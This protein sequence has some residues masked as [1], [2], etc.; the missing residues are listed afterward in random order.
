MKENVRECWGMFWN[1]NAKLD[2]PKKGMVMEDR[3]VGMH[4]MLGKV[5][6]G[7]LGNT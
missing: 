3:K 2:I 1:G 6:I 4:G 7:M 5:C